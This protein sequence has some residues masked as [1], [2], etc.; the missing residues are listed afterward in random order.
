MYKHKVSEEE[1]LVG[2]PQQPR[3]TEAKLREDSGSADPA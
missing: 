2:I 1:T 3:P